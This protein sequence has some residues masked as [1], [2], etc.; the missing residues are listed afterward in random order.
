MRSLE[1]SARGGRDGVDDLGVVD[2][3]EVDAGDAEVAVAE[4]ALDDLTISAT[5]SRASSTACAWRSWCGAKRRRTP[6]ATAVSRGSVRAA[7]L[8][9]WRSRV[10]PLR[11]QNKGPMGSS[12]RSSSHG[13]SSSQRHAS[14]PTSRRRPTVAVPHEQGAAALIE[15]GLGEG[16]MR[17]GAG[18]VERAGWEHEAGGRPFGPAAGV[19]TRSVQAASR[20]CL[21]RGLGL[22]AMAKDP[23]HDGVRVRPFGD[24]RS[25]LHDGA[26]GGMT[27]GQASHQVPNRV[28]VHL[29]HRRP[30]GVGPQPR[31]GHLW[32]GP[33]RRTQPAVRGLAT[34]CWQRQGCLPVRPHGPGIPGIS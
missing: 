30:L 13:S 14:M 31:G 16:G 12:V 32:P 18:S 27:S 3:L 7:A 28:V 34:A 8:D 17:S 33:G 19:K 11:M 2:A 23:R 9:H 24:D 20:R 1:S 6:A 26:A 22:S 4:L 5:P 10:G 15:N 25:P 29:D 21:D